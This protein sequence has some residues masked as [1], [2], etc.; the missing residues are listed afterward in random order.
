MRSND[1][2]DVMTSKYLYIC[3]VWFLGMK[4]TKLEGKI[5]IKKKNN[6]NGAE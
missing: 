4:I 6:E 2:F 1:A 3:K 5:K